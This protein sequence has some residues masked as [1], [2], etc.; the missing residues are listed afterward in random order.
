MLYNRLKRAKQQEGTELLKQDKE[1]ISLLDG[2]NIPL[3][4]VNL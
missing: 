4:S 1:E 3:D 2:V